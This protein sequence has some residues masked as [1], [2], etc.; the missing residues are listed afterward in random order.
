MKNKGDRLGWL[1]IKDYK[2]EPVSKIVG[3]RKIVEHMKVEIEL[4][5]L[6]AIKKER[7]YLKVTN[8]EL[9][10]KI[11]SLNERKII[12]DAIELSI[13][14]LDVYIEKIFSELGFDTNYYGSVEF[15]PRD[16]YLW[17][18]GWWNKEDVTVKLSA[19]ITDEMRRAFLKIGIIASDDNKKIEDIIDKLSNNQSFITKKTSAK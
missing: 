17:N 4:E 13:K 2:P 14:L 7:D 18:T 9:E 8:K 15:T 19:H 5:E 16:I 1:P 12:K 11:E 10:E 6:T 3:N